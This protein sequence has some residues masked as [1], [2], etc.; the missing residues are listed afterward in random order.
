MAKRTHTAIMTKVVEEAG[1]CELC[2]ST[3][4]LEAHHIIPIVC[5]GNDSERN[6]IC[7]CQSC[8]ARLTPRAEL[9]KYGREKSRFGG[10]KNAFKIDLYNKIEE[11]IKRDEP[12]PDINTVFD[13]IRDF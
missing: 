2:G 8:H 11:Y 7:V 10:D 4:G 13:A 3:R 6:L 1:R 5:G 12:F 9:L